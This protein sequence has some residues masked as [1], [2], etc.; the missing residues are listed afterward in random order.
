MTHFCFVPAL[1]GW[2]SG[3]RLRMQA[4]PA[5]V[6]LFPPRTH[7]CSFNSDWIEW[8][9]PG[10]LCPL[11]PSELTASSA[12]RYFLTPEMEEIKTIEIGFFWP[13][14]NKSFFFFAVI[15]FFSKH[16]DYA[17]MNES[18]SLVFMESLTSPWWPGKANCVLVF[19]GELKTVTSS[20]TEERCFLGTFLRRPYIKASH[21]VL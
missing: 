6:L 17:C 8:N 7:G 1:W 2:S 9:C 12:V 20:W 13:Y 19:W 21:P 15:L 16:K 18:C 10:V 11:L 3:W 4:N 14:G 5:V